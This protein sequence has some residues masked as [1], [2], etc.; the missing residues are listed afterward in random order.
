MRTCVWVVVVRVCVCGGGLW[1]HSYSAVSTLPVRF[2]KFNT[3][4]LASCL[5]W[6]KKIIKSLA[7]KSWLMEFPALLD[8]DT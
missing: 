7:L 6:M 4:R 2:N 3:V 8:C 5:S 1:L